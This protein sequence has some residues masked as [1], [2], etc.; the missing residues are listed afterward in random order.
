MKYYLIDYITYDGEHEYTEHGVLSARTYD[1][2]RKKAKKGRKF[3]TRYGW[4]EFC[5][6]YHVQEIPRADFWVLTK[7]HPTLD[8]LLNGTEYLFR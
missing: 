3:L 4:E 8:R 2:A 1:V 7:Y 6:L 5:E